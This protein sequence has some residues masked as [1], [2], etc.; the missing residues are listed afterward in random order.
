[1]K[2]LNAAQMHQLD[3]YTQEI[4]H[5]SSLQLMERAATAF[6]DYFIQQISVEQE[7]WIFCGK[8]NNGGDGLAIARLL[9]LRG[10]TVKPFL[11]NIGL[12][13]DDCAANLEILMPL[14]SVNDLS[15]EDDIPAISNN[16]VIVDALLGSGLNKEVTGIYARLIDAINTSHTTVYSVDVPS[17]MYCDYPAK[18]TSIIKADYTL[19]FHAPKLMF[20]LSDNE[21]YTGVWHVL[22]IG[23]KE[24]GTEHVAAN[25][26]YTNAIIIQSLIHKRPVFSNKGTFGKALLI[27]GSKGM[28][29]AAALSS[30]A[31]MRSGVGLVCAHIPACGVEILQSLL[32]EAVLSIDTQ[33]AVV[34]QLPNLKP[35]NA[36][37]I[38]SGLGEHTLTVTALKELLEVIDALPLVIDA[39]ALNILASHTELMKYIPPNSILT[40]HPKELERLAGITFENSWE[41]LLK[42]IELAKAMQ[43]IIVL[44]GAYSAVI[45]PTGVVHFNSTGNSGM[46]TAGSGDVLTGIITALLAQG[47]V[48]EDAAKIGVFAHG[49]AGDV[50]AKKISKSAMI[51]SDI[52]DH[53][54]DFFLA[55]E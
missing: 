9:I 42:G 35:Y 11:L 52:V 33:D 3:A 34:S 37:G 26:F 55:F 49:Y 47:Y 45:M 32:P 15:T 21:S 4:E 46:A 28:M 36:I 12:L 22:D 19:T 51:A 25:Y 50:A 38:G 43:V 10:F 7:V 16:V 31:C 1:M 24:E 40:P 17:G 14:V 39:S 48:P 27:V 23:L 5:I 30:K 18:H 6:V 53:L 8:G 29:G 20:F 54:S 41:R 44:K 2:V 13:S